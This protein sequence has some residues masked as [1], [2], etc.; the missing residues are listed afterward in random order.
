MS[1]CRDMGGAVNGE[2]SDD[3]IVDCHLDWCLTPYY[4]E[5]TQIIYYVTATV[6]VH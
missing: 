5:F 4:G 2:P 3:E 6:A 1:E